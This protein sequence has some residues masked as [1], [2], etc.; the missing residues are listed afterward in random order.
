LDLL[1]RKGLHSHTVQG[2][3]HHNLSE[4]LLHIAEARF[5]DLWLVVGKVEKLE[6]LRNHSPQDLFDLATSIVDNYASTAAL[7]KMDAQKSR[8]DELLY[9]SAQMARDLLDYVDFDDAIKTGD[10]GRI[11][12]LLPQL[13]FRF[14]GGKNKNYATELLELLQ[15]LLKEWPDDLK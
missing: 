6:D 9:Q 13:L 12:D 3:F 8:K 1:K 15:G 5:R 10:I 7:R 14:A 11:Q 2:T 4:A